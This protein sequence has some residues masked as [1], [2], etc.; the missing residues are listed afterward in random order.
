MSGELTMESVYFTYTEDS[1]SIKKLTYP[2]GTQFEFESRQ[3]KVVEA[4]PQCRFLDYGTTPFMV[5]LR[6]RSV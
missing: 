2:R 3:Y 1:G 4:M 6:C 5:R